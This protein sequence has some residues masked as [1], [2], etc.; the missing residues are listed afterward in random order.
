MKLTVA[1]C[2]LLG[3][4]A[5][6]AQDTAEMSAWMKTIGPTNGSI[7]KNIEAKQGSD[8]AKEAQKLADVYKQVGAYFAKMNADDAVKIAKTGEDAANDLVAAA[9]AGDMDK[10]SAD[11][12]AIGGTCG[13]CHSA[14]REKLE[15][16]GYKIK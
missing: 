14:H 2:L 15:G 3:A 16:G 8:A 10:A 11:A 7:R 6:S 12:K 13:P 5:V 4:V 1:A 9:T